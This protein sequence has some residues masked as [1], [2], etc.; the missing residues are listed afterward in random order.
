MTEQRFR[1]MAEYEWAEEQIRKAQN[2]L[3]EGK[4]YLAKQELIEAAGNIQTIVEEKEKERELD[5]EL[6]REP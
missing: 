3:D 4:L 2:L 5:R 1:N 6:N